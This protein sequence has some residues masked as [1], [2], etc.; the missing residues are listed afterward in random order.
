M[1]LSAALALLSCAEAP[2]PRDASQP[3]PA[4][5]SPA[6]E[7][8]A[9]GAADTA[10]SSE[11]KAPDAAPPPSR[12]ASGVFP[13]PNLAPPF[14]RSA[15]PG[16]GEWT[17]V[18]EAGEVD[19]APIVYTT[20]LRPH[21]FKRFSY[22]QV[23]AIDLSRVELHLAAGSKE[24]LSDALPPEAR[25]GMVPE[26]SQSRLA[27][28]FN[29]GFM[30]RHGGH[31]MGLGEV[32]LVSPRDELCTVALLPDGGVKI[33][34]WER[35][36]GEREGL[37]AFRQSPW[38]LVEDGATSPK[39]KSHEQ[40]RYGLSAEGKLEIR[41]SAVAV[42]RDERT[43]YYAVGEEQTPEL[44]AQA[45]LH[46]GV[47]SAAQLDINWSYTRFLFFQETDGALQV[48]RSLLPKMK[49]TKTGYVARSQ[50]RD[51]FYVLRQK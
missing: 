31:G 27:A 32:D 16:D 4:P 8:R 7:P 35:L 37:S 39:V 34:S 40:R 29:G 21:P 28:V 13:P 33:A 41:R 17:P 36:R 6:A 12:L 46:L 9:E 42:S 20:S 22:V 25:P 45:M 14:E 23:A 44:I 18:P 49:Y 15:Q 26:A 10:G 43:L 47:E 11:T 24:P 3:P 2:P 5:A 1:T 50:E 51:F 30:T 19:G 48:T 38:C